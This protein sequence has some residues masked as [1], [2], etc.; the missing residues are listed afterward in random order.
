MH[1]ILLGFLGLCEQDLNMNTSCGSDALEE[2]ME[3]EEQQESAEA[4]VEEDVDEGAVCAP[5]TPVPRPFCLRYSTAKTN[6]SICITKYQRI[7]KDEYIKS[8]V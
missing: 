3:A 5:S 7:S 6:F 1:T 8:S 2:M 4:T